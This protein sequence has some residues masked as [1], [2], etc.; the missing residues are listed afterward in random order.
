[1]NYWLFAL[2]IQ[3]NIVLYTHTAAHNLTQRVIVRVP[4]KT[5]S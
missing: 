4:V 2:I 3:H 5:K 1:M